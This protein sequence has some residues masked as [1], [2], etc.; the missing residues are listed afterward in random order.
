MQKNR[1]TR[2][3]L[4]VLV[5]AGAA[6]LTPAYADILYSNLGAG[7]SFDSGSAF[8]IGQ[9]ASFTQVIAE[10]FTTTGSAQF[11]DAQLALFAYGGTSTD[12]YLESDNSGAPGSVLDTLVEQS[13]VTGYPGSLITFDCSTCVTLAVSTRYWIV[14]AQGN[15]PTAWSYNNTGDHSGVL[16]DYTGSITGPFNSNSSI[17]RGAFEVDGSTIASSVPEPSAIALLFTV[18]GLAGAGL[19]RKNRQVAL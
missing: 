16:F 15:G 14:A 19:R 10:S 13:P 3:F 11:E 12:V 9:I 8:N 18:V 7:G 6:G 1:F 5:L 4:A 17:T 2:R